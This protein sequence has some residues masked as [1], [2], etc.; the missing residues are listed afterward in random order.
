M[1]DLISV[2]IPVYNV[3]KYLKKCIYSVVNQTFQ[4]IEIILVDDGSTDASGDIC[5]DFAKLD[6]RIKAFHKKNGGLSSARNFGIKKSTG[7]FLVFVDSD[8]WISKNM[9]EDLYNAAKKND[10]KIVCCG[11]N[12]VE[13][14]KKCIPIHVPE[15]RKFST[16]EAVKEILFDS[17]VGVAAW[18]KIFHIDTIKDIPFPEGEIHEDVA[19]MCRVFDKCDSIYAISKAEYYYRIHPSGLSK[20]DYSVQYDVVLKH[21][22]NNEEYLRKYHPKLRKAAE[23]A[24]AHAC[25][26]MLIK[27][28]K[29]PNGNVIFEKELKIY[30]KNLVHRIAKYW[31]LKRISIKRLVWSLIFLFHNRVTNRLYKLTGIY[32]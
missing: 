19:I 7:N 14:G 9:I 30:C 24:V 18:G 8:D 16:E 4:N 11:R 6:R 25:L 31:T 10:V 13:D 12:I 20:Q 3:E 17:E 28:S 15:C 23:A 2:I 26:D 29:T 27:I 21:V 1:N 32:K 22:L 5:D